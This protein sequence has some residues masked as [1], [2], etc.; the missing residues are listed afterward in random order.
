[1]AKKYDFQPDKPYSSWLNKLQLTKL[2][3]KQV[4][5][6]CLYT[7][8]LILLSVVQDVVM[9]RIRIFEGTT[10][11]VPCA[12]LVIGILEGTQQGSVFALAASVFYL[13][14]G[15][16]P[17]AHVL[18]LL[19]VLTVLAGAV[20]QTYLHPRLPAMMLTAGFAMLTYE[21]AIFGFC[22]LLEQ[23]TVA[24]LPGFLVPAVLA[25]AI[26]P[27][28]YPVLKAIS[29]IGGEAWKE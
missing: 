17:G 2:Q 24:R 27:I 29:K 4:L 21:M 7:L 25:L 5:K 15:S 19:T 13:L 22:L 14:S 10:D 26:I 3:Q 16:A 1:M 18:V 12:I 23:I 6:W 20:R 28:L 11:L 9:C 8:V